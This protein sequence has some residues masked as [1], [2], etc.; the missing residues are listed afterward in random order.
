MHIRVDDT[1][2]ILS[3]DDKGKKGKVLSVDR[4]ANKVT[5]QGINLVYKNLRKSQQSPQGG[6]LS[7]EMP[8]SAS[9]VSLLDPSSNTPTRVGVRTASNGDKELYAKKSGQTIRVLA[10]AKV[11]N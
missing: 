8:V 11:A 9:N 2:I 4:A 3:G 6:K 7:R 1:V 10:K 5:V